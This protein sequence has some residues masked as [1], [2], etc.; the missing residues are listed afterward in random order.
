ME[1]HLWVH[2]GEDLS[3]NAEMKHQVY[4]KRVPTSCYPIELVLQHQN[5]KRLISSP[6][7]ATGADHDRL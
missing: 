5:Q 2:V 4:S 7:L 1:G 6:K 3:A